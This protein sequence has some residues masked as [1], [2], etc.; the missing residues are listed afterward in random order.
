MTTT[1]SPMSTCVDIEAP[2]D[3][4]TPIWPTVPHPQVTPGHPSP[5]VPY[6]QVPSRTSYPESHVQ[7]STPVQTRSWEE[8]PGPMQL[9]TSPDLSSSFSVTQQDLPGVLPTPGREMHQLTSRVQGNWDT[10]LDFVETQTK[11]VGEL[12]QGLKAASSQHSDQINN[13]STKVSD[14][15]QQVLTLLA[16]SGKQDESEADQLTKAIKLMISGELQ[17]VESTVVSEVRFMVDQLQ[18]EVQQ[19]LKTMQQHFQKSHDQLTTEIQ[20]CNSQTASLCTN[21]R[22]FETEMTD[23]CKTQEKKMVALLKERLPSPPVSTSLPSL[24]PSPSVTT[25]APAS[26]ATGV[27]SDHLK[28]TFPTFGRQSDDPDPLLYLARCQDFLALHPLVDADLLATFRTVLYGT[29]R[30]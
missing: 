28:L 30:D 5:Y 11:A 25:L 17:K 8:G 1:P 20:Q 13:L 16:T 14:N 2:P 26:A 10:L 12:T 19:D 6:P 9:C 4:A 15:Q 3:V 24:P 29:A 18:L 27:R 23:Q 21:L 7:F 22:K